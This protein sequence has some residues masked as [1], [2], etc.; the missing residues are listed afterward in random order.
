MLSRMCDIT[1]SW[2]G[3]KEMVHTNKNYVLSFCAKLLM[4]INGFMSDDHTRKEFVRMIIFVICNICPT[5]GLGA[6]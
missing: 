5:V 1:L 4:R 2:T 6:S 3:R